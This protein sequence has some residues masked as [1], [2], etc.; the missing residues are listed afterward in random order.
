MILGRAA[1]GSQ[2][3]RAAGSLIESNLSFGPGRMMA[4]CFSETPVS[5]KEFRELQEATK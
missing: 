4:A 1:K 2:P 3:A 5:L